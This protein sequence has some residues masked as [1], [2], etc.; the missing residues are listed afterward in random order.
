MRPWKTSHAASVTA[1]ILICGAVLAAG[2]VRAVL[3]S[4]TGEVKIKRAAADD[5][6]RVINA[7]Q[8]NLYGGDHLLTM[9]RARA[10][11]ALDGAR[12][13]IGPSTHIVIPDG[14]SGQPPRR[15]GLWLFIGRVF[16]WLVGGRQLELGTQAAVAAAEGTRFVA[17]A[18]EDGVITLTVLEGSVALYNDLGRVLVG[19]GEQSSAGPGMAPTRPMQ[20]DPSGFLE[21]EASL[22]AVAP[23]WESRSFPDA[24]RDELR[25]MLDDAQAA[26][27]A[28]PE[29]APALARL[30]AV[31]LD[32]G[33][34]VAAA[35]AAA[36][37]LNLDDPPPSAALTLGRA[38]LRQSQ[39]REAMAAFERAAQSPE[40]AAEARLGI[41]AANLAAG[42][43]DEAQKAL[44]AAHAAGA[45]PS[46]ADAMAGLIALHSGD[47]DAAEAPLRSALEADPVAWQAHAFMAD[48]QLV[49]GDGEAALEHAARAVEMAPAS[50]LG[51]RVAGTV[52]YFT[53]DM[54]QAM[55]QSQLALSWDRSSGRAH[56]L[57]SHLLAT[58]GDLD[59]ALAD[60]EMAVALSPDHALAHA[61][62][63][64]LLLA[65]GEI[66]G[67]EKSFARALE[68]DPEL[69]TARTGM[70]R[71]WARQGRMAEAM[72]QH[73]AAIALDAGAASAW[74]NL[75]AIHLAL[76]RLEEAISEFE[77]ALELQPRWAIPHANMAIAY[78]ES[79]RF[80]EALD[81]ARQAQELGG[82]S[83]RVLTTLARVYLEQGRINLARVAL[84]RALELD[85]EFALAHLEMAEVYN[86]QGR[87]REALAHQ[88]RSLTQQPAAI[89][90]TRE[91]SRTEA[92]LGIGSTAAELKRDGRGNDGQDSYM[93]HGSYRNEW[94][95]P[96]AG[97]TEATALAI[98]GRQHDRD[99]TSAVWLSAE[100]SER[101]RPGAV[102][103]AGAV[104]DS[105]YRSDFTGFDLKYLTR[106]PGSDDSAWTFKAGYLSSRNEDTNPNALVGDPKPF[107][108]LEVRRSGPTLEAR[109]D[110]PAGDDE[111]T[112]G[113]ALFGEETS[114]EGQVGVVNPPGSQQRITWRPFSNTA[115]RDAASLYGWYTHRPEVD[116]ELTVG[117]RVA[118]REGMEQVARPEGW[119]RHA[120]SDDST[121]VLLTRPVLRDDVSE[122]GPVNDWALRPW[123]SPLD[124]ATGGYSQT[125]E[126]V[127][128]RTPEDG[129]VLRGG[130]FFRSLENLI[131]DLEDPALSP[132]RMGLV[133]ASADVRGG[134][135]E[136]ERWLTENLSGG[137]WVRYT[138]TDNNAPGGGELPMQPDWTG[139]LR[140]DYIDRS[141]IRAS[142]A[143]V[144]VGERYA[145]A[146]NA[147]Q[148]DAFDIVNL[149]LRKQFGLHT[150][151]FLSVR[152]V[153]DEEYAFWP[154]YPGR[155]AS[156]HGGV[157]YRF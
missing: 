13:A 123:L 9:Q 87:P 42:R 122:L 10:V 100:R 8:R 125:W 6:L 43:G 104:D 105:N 38:L 126:A 72:E 25:G 37:A 30:A 142:V 115:D 69:V 26:V 120:L 66:K 17:E 21:W 79:N 128:E 157:E 52:Y 110:Y 98:G 127:Y 103:G 23:E 99:R 4:V 65:E 144:H 86:S 62:L 96:Q 78:L 28:A 145:D 89:V 70:G 58:G 116:T 102:I 106:V 40:T 7:S 45:D 67:A 29:D 36:G 11:V 68:L 5:W 41:A 134:E 149:H 129:S 12:I 75:G 64:M 150:D 59:G 132:G 46:T 109:L 130:L 35:E 44:A 81:H 131:V 71:T 92:V 19:E 90:D 117:G 27:Q 16:V 51:R 33:D 83:A 85:E 143:W 97:W 32:L 113:V 133:V 152:N 137:V 118:M 154:G 95:R 73:K 24:T 80:A 39:A 14:E 61:A 138:D 74:N 88:L 84:R 18:D 111:V 141:G 48:L 107:R 53:G 82:E 47:S 56:L 140:L 91:Y 50:P 94:E 1:L 31:Q 124:L 101:D 135:I 54:L 136:W 20:V 60:A 57:H 76:G 93:L 156:V 108:R 114:A 146:A 63:G 15:K 112:A 155:S 139:R 3:E 151:L 55:E 119:V 22:E 49:Q 148:L 121:V 153:F 2:G 34:P 147:V 77:R